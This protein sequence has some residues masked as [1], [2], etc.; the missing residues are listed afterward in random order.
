MGFPY[1]SP[2]CFCY[3]VG[4]KNKELQY[5]SIEDLPA[6]SRLVL[7]QACSNVFEVFGLGFV[8][9]FRYKMQKVAMVLHHQMLPCNV[10]TLWYYAV[11]KGN[12]M[13]ISAALA[14]TFSQVHLLLFTLIPYIISFAS[15]LTL[16]LLAL[17]LL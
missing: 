13:I 8:L 16:I 9:C 14:I 17:L 10:S 12:S 15:N 5:A 3:L 2:T 1:L 4:G 11:S 7:T 6:D